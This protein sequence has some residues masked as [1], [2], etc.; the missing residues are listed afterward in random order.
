MF[1]DKT[2][3]QLDGLFIALGIAGGSDFAKKIGV[4][5]ENDRIIVNENMETNIPGIFACGNITGGLLQ[6]SKAVYEGAVAGLKAVD[7]IKNPH[8]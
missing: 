2:E 5:S 7:Y 3:M 4:M 1:E 8:E 6:V